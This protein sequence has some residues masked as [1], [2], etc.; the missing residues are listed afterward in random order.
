MMKKLQAIGL[1]AVVGIAIAVCIFVCQSKQ[2]IAQ[3][4]TGVKIQAGGS[5][6]VGIGHDHAP[7]VKRSAVVSDTPSGDV[8]PTA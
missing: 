2:Q 3:S 7:K 6:Y 4:Q 8:T 1:F 5:N